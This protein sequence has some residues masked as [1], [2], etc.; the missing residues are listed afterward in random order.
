M[1]AMSSVQLKKGFSL[2]ELLV[3]VAII[4]VL[5]AIGT[6]G[7]GNYVT[8][9]RIKVNATN[10]ANFGGGI[11][12]KVATTV[13]GIDTKV[14]TNCSNFLDTMITEMNASSPVNAYNSSSREPVYINQHTV[15]TKKPSYLLD[16]SGNQAQPDPNMGGML[17][18]NTAWDPGQILVMCSD[19]CASDLQSVG[20]SACSCDGP[21]K[22]VS[23]G[24]NEGYPCPS[25]GQ[26][27]A[28]Q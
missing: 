13:A 26:V 8:Q 18:G 4:G 12:T 7:Y 21:G 28:C 6:V 9:T 23:N 3:V 22:C 17:I 1:L 11:Q 20:F 5:A 14:Y 15:G 19:P 10:I 2:I 24:A 27:S 16:A 25:H